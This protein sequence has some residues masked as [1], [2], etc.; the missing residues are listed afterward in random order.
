MPPITTIT[1]A[2]EVLENNLV[3]QLIGQGY[4]RVAV[5]DEATMLAV[6]GAGGGIQRPAAGADRA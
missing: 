6:S 5:T 4:T 3:A 2:E 1:Q